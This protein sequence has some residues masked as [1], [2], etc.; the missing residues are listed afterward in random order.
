EVLMYGRVVD[1][2]SQLG[3]AVPAGTP[4]AVLAVGRMRRVIVKFADGRTTDILTS[5]VERMGRGAR[6][7]DAPAFSQ[8][9]LCSTSGYTGP[10]PASRSRQAAVVRLNPERVVSSSSSTGPA[11]T[12]PDTDSRSSAPRAE[13]ALVAASAWNPLPSAVIAVPTSCIRPSSASRPARSA[14]RVGCRR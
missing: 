13:S 6:L 11:G 2:G 9:T 5:M 8:I 14:S 4:A 3:V 10:A 12:G 7:N 1:I